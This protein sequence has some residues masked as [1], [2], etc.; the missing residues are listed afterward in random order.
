MIQFK[1]LHEDAQLPEYAT[2]DA[3]GM[4]VRSIDTVNI[5]PGQTTMVKTGL[6]VAIPRGFELQCRPRSGLAAKHR[7]TITNAPGT[8]DADYRGEIC[9]LLHNLGNEGFQV[10]KGDRIAQLVLAYAPRLDIEEVDELDST[11]RGA[12]GFGSTGRK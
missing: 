11:D 6:A 4:D 2:E 10:V 12:G 3:A 7:I 8:I 5:L 1:R 9:V